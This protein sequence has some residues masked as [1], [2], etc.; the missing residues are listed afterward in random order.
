MYRE[1]PRACDIDDAYE[2]GQES[3]LKDVDR[4]TSDRAL[5]RRQ[6]RYRLMDVN[7]GVIT[8]QLTTTRS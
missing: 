5:A 6:R 2:H 4:A 1:Q 3:R 8:D 7:A